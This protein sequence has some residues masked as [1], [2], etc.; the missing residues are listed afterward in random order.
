MQLKH[1]P[2][3][4]VVKCQ[5][6][7]SRSQN[8][9]IARTHLAEKLEV[10]E[11]GDESRLSIKAEVKRKKK[12]SASKKSRRKYRALEAGNAATEI[13]DEEDAIDEDEAEQAEREE[14]EPE[15]GSGEGRDT[16]LR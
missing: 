2:T 3:G 11:K 16:A 13:S 15:V 4:I 1:L 5:E 8:R 6:T 12:S 10:L 9:K 14:L 7:R